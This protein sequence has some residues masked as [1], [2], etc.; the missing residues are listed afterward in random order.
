MPNKVAATT[1]N[2][3]RGRKSLT[4]PFMAF[5]K[6]VK[7]IGLEL[8]TCRVAANTTVFWMTAL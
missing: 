3:C 4:L 7:D 8:F 1:T 5:A 2:W 6:T